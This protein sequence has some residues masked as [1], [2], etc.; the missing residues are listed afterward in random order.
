MLRR[1]LLAMLF[2]VL[3]AC[4][5]PA[6]ISPGMTRAHI[7]DRLAHVLHG[8]NYQCGPGEIPDQLYCRHP[9]NLDV[10][11]AYLPQLHTLQI[12]VG[13]ERSTDDGLND[14]WRGDCAQVHAKINEVN[15]GYLTKLT[16]EGDLLYFTFYS[17]LP[18]G[19]MSEQDV[20]GLLQIVDDA[21]GDAIKAS[22]MLKP[23]ENP[24]ANS[25]PVQT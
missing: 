13:F 19:G 11:F 12:Y 14:L 7:N 18:E 15:A 17:W 3:P 22:G 21:V 1:S 20:T 9:D 2:P 4:A 24:P 23:E 25:G 8:Q 16:C 10:S 6:A 5:T